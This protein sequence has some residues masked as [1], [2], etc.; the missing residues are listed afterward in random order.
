[1]TWGPEDALQTGLATPL[2]NETV[3]ADMHRV[4][5]LAGDDTFKLVVAL[6]ETIS[7]LWRPLDGHEPR[8]ST[9]A[10]AASRRVDYA[11]AREAYGALER[12]LRRKIGLRPD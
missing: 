1:M 6:E 3:L 8:L 2:M 7:I 9:A 5:L 11:R 12:H 4:S 10:L